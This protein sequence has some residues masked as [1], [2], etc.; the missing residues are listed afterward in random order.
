MDSF[1]LNLV[2]FS[3]LFNLLSYPSHGTIFSPLERSF[4]LLI[5]LTDHEFKLLN[6][7]FLIAAFIT[8]VIWISY[9]LVL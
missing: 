6:Q 1:L 7:L 9:V 4:N 2:H 8:G 5:D 3:R